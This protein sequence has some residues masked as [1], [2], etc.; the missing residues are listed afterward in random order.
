MLLK[1]FDFRNEILR[2]IFVYEDVF[3]VGKLYNDLVV[4][5]ML[6]EFGMKK[7]DSIIVKDVLESVWLVVFSF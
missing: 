7:E 6:E 4:F 1:V 3:F 5:V 2:K